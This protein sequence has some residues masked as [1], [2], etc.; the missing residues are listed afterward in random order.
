MRKL[1][2]DEIFVS[3]HHTARI[4]A[5]AVAAHYKVYVLNEDTQASVPTHTG[6][7]AS[8]SL[9]SSATLQDAR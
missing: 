5:A 8:I 9:S 1:R 4:K 3:E 7:L 6:T 2:I